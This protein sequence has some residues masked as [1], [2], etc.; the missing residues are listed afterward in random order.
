MQRV[1]LSVGRVS[2]NSRLVF[3]FFVSA[4]GCTRI[5]LNVTRLSGAYA[6]SKLSPVY[7]CAVCARIRS[8][9]SV[10]ARRSEIN[11]VQRGVIQRAGVSAKLYFIYIAAARNLLRSVNRNM[12]KYLLRYVEIVKQRPCCAYK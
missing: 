10:G 2:I 4:R 1:Y 12:N 6:A 7:N 8:V 3:S 9:F 5:T 11:V